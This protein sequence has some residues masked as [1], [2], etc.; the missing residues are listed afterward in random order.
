MAAGQRL[1]R[2]DPELPLDQVLAGNHLGHRVLDLEPG[3]H[4]HEVEVVA[5]AEELDRARAQIAAGL[6]RGHRRGA[7]LGAPRRAQPRR[8]RLLDHL[9]MAALDRAVALE[10][11]QDVAAAV[12]EDLDLDVTRALQVGLDDDPV[13]AE[14][15]A[16]LA[17]GGL[18]RGIEILGPLD[19]PHALAAAPG[20]GLDQHR[21]AGPGRGLSEGL[22]VL[23]GAMVAGHQRHSGLGHDLLGRR[24]GA[25]RPDRRR[26]RADEDQAGVHAGLGEIGILGQEAVTGMDC[27]GAGRLGRGDDGLDVQVALDGRRRPDAPRL[28]GL[29]HV[30][31]S[32]IGIGVDRHRGDAH[33]PRRAHDAAGDLAPVG[34][35]DL[36]EHRRVDPWLV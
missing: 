15:R 7:H 33:A 34:D 10:E 19:H 6:G 23:G 22:R 32:G 5:A 20:R 11:M 17:P 9:L 12:G 25:E 26:R 28:V 14:S 35:Q 27:L 1:P 21:V 8:R 4:L 36:S 31:R 13:V 16:G 18:E 29:R 30:R 24:L 3:V 2:R